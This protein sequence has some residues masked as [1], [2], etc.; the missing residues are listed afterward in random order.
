MKKVLKKTDA[1]DDS[2]WYELLGISSSSF[3][4]GVSILNDG[5]IIYANSIFHSNLGF[6]T[7]ELSGRD[8]LN[9]IFPDDR[10]LIE[11]TLK[12]SRGLHHHSQ[13][14]FINKV[15]E[16]RYV[17]LTICAVELKAKPSILVYATDVTEQ[18]NAQGKVKHLN[19]ALNA[20]INVNRIM[21]PENDKECLL[22]KICNSLIST[23]GY[24]DAWI[25]ILDEKRNLS[26]IVEPKTNS[27]RPS[28]AERLVCRE[29][30]NCALKA[31]GKSQVVTVR[32]PLACRDCP[33]ATQ[34]PDRGTIAV[35]LKYRRKLYGLLMVSLPKF[36]LNDG[37]E[38]SLVQGLSNDI[39]FALYRIEL[40][41]KHKLVAKQLKESE[42]FSSSILENS[43]HP[44]L[45]T[46]PDTSIIYVNPALEKLTGFFFSELIGTK[47]PYPWDKDNTTSLTDNNFS[48][49]KNYNRRR[50]ERLFFRK[51]GEQFSV[52]ISNVSI[53]NSGKIKYYLT[54]WVDLSEQKLLKENERYYI[55]EITKA[56]EEERK[57]IARDL[58]DDTAQTLASLYM[59]I[60]AITRL[61]KILPEDVSSRL[62][63][64]SEKIDKALEEVRRFSYQ[65]RPGL[66]DKYGLIPSIEALVEELRQCKSLVVHL[67]VLGSERRLSP[68]VE[69]ALF[70]ITQ[71]ALTNVKKHS[72]ANE[73]L[74]RVMFGD[75]QLRLT[76]KDN[77]CG[78]KL[79]KGPEYLARFG[80]LGLIGMYERAR[81]INGTLT[82]TS[83]KGTSITIT[84]PFD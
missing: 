71:E 62:F 68:Q 75:N 39:A 53:R 32:E 65:L 3:P 76:I 19:L 1:S 54:N 13:C 50:K 47:A 40:E 28:V 2:H 55:I 81:L 49:F 78:F 58:H 80:K 48:K 17:M 12:I 9:I 33:I 60:N 10:P 30:P 74:I 63:Q 43:P 44:I 38:M 52:E 4:F 29:L 42:Q 72:G 41:T 59:E 11:S 67:K 16:I 82:V 61:E 73:V 34:Y 35:K 56:Q 64:I 5:I 46:S 22:S 20:I 23:R 18:K 45:V 84:L 6:E 27:G 26:L 83:R 8:F 79:P 31:L 24:Y 25:G 66:L 37:E 57:R 36:F 15:G 14:R 7:N 69:L 70:R 21:A 77:G 51:N